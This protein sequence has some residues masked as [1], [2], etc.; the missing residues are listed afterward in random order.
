QWE[1]RYRSAPADRSGDSLQP[2]TIG[3]HRTPSSSALHRTDGA[4]T[5]CA[6]QAIS[7]GYRRQ[8]GECER[9]LEALA[10]VTSCFQQLATSLGSCADGHFLREEME[11]ARILAQQLCGGVSGRLLHVMSECDSGPHEDRQL[12]ERLWV[13]FLSALEN[14]LLSLRKTG[15]LIGHF[16]LSQRSDR[17][18]LVQTGCTDGVVG[19]VLRSGAIQTPSTRADLPNLDLTSHMAALEELLADMQRRVP[20]P[21]WS[22]EAS[23]LAWSEAQGDTVD[24]EDTLEDLMEVEVVNSPTCCPRPCCGLH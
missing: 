20:V 3:N 2:E 21:F 11:D 13:H 18:S 22:I 7:S 9:A 19:L 6:R 4:R 5:S 17:R 15:D 14:L 24:H 16:P 23:Q 1:S 10:E 8:Q 12:W